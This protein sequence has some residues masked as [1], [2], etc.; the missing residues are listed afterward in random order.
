MTR[1]AVSTAC[2]ISI[3]ALRVE[4]DRRKRCA[5]WRTSNFYPRPP[6]GGRRNGVGITIHNAHFYPRPP[7]GG[8]PALFSASLHCERP[9]LSTPSGWRAT[10]RCAAALLSLSG[11]SI[12]ALR[13][14]GDTARRGRKGAETYFYPRPPGGGR[15]IPVV[16]LDMIAEFLSTPSG[17]RATRHIDLRKPCIS[18]LSTPSGWR[19]TPRYPKQKAARRISIHALRV[20]GDK[21]YRPS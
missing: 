18:F 16:F 17:W 19:A 15:P 5:S 12:H 14:E 20:E 6:G 8:R 7:G 1:F 4:G 10:C 2:F 13:V 9:F 3:H 11:I 21:A